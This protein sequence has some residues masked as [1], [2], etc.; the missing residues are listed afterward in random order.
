MS[1]L[2]EA[3][4]VY[5]LIDLTRE[6]KDDMAVYPGDDN[7]KLRQIKYIK[8]DGYNDH[9]LETGMHVGTHLDGP[10]HMTESDTYISDIE[11]DRLIGHGCFIN[12]E[13]QDTINYK[14]EYEEK[15]HEQSIVLIYTGYDK[16]FGTEKYFS[17]HP[18][19]SEDLAR[20]LIRKK[21]K[22]LG[23]DTPSPDRYP[24]NI[25]KLLLSNKVLIAE[26]LA[27][28]DKLMEYEKFKAFV[29]PLNI[30]ADGAAARV[31]ARIR[32]I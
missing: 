20:L 22:V 25:H 12:A 11:L 1:F 16:H 4:K 14:D 3:F 7:M 27:N 19:I 21:V 13:G 28:L 26:N 17:S 6:L 23:M 29:I 2:G 30:R 5:R 10:M 31:F 15:I 32:D 24:F 18:V 8:A 9:R